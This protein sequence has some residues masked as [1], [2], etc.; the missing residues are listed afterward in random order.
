MQKILNGLMFLVVLGCSVA[1]ISQDDDFT[2]V[3]PRG[4]ATQSSEGWGGNPQRALDGNTD[5]QWGGGSVTHTNGA[6]SWW[7]VDLRDT[8]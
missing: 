7:E 4:I 1:G 6:P 8:Y 2:N 3:G 5:G